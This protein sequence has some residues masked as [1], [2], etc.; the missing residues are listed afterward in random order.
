M[1][2][3]L[4]ETFLRETQLRQSSSKYNWSRNLQEQTFGQTK[5]K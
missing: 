1:S 4:K 5:T 3:I 2:T